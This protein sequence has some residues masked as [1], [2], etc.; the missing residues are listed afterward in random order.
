MGKLI[1]VTGFGGKTTVAANLAWLLGEENLTCLW[2]T[3]LS[4]GSIGILFGTDIT[5]EKSFTKISNAIDIDLAAAVTEVKGRNNLF[6]LS[7]HSQTTYFDNLGKDGQLSDE[8]IKEL[9]GELK[10]KFEY[11]VVDC[12]RSTSNS[13]KLWAMVHADK[14]INLIKPDICGL[15]RAKAAKPFIDKFHK[16]I[17]VLYANENAVSYGYVEDFYGSGFDITLPYD[18]AVKQS[19]NEGFPIASTG[20]CKTDY[21]KNLKEL[22]KL[23]RGGITGGN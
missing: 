23:V 21:C 19:T 10:N 12:D 7:A 8:R 9:I 17:N 3:D 11:I 18:T 1:A 20:K 6:L 5:A 13:Y 2:D 15:V 14:I 16:V 4:C 22:L